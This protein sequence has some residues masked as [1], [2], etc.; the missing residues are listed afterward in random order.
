[1]M[2]LEQLVKAQPKLAE[3]IGILPETPPKPL[4]AIPKSAYTRGC[5][6]VRER[7]WTPEIPPS[8]SF[9][10]YFDAT[11]HAEELLGFH[12]AVGIDLLQADMPRAVITHPKLG[13]RILE[14]EVIYDEGVP[15][16]LQ[17]SVSALPDPTGC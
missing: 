17:Y 2:T 7:V 15:F 1:M 16:A 6:L 4:N 14:L 5:G 10:G 9:V 8:G 12:D 3:R 11:V 13:R